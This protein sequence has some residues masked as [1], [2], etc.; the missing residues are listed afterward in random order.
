MHVDSRTAI[1]RDEAN[2]LA[3][4]FDHQAPERLIRWALETFGSPRVLICTSFQVE[5]MVILDL[6]AR[7]EPNIRVATIDTGRLPTATYEMMDRVRDKYDLEVETVW[8]D[9]QDVEPMVRQHGSNLFYHDESLRVMCC[10]MR[11]VRPLR[12][13]LS[14][15]DAW[16]TG[17]RREQSGLR[18]SVRTIEL[19]E[20]HENRIKISPLAYWTEEMVWDY[21][22][23]NDVPIHPLYA[24]GYT[25]IGCEPC[26]R[27]ITPG[28][29]H[30]AGRW[31]WEPNIAKECGLHFTVIPT[32]AEP[33]AVQTAWSGTTH[34]LSAAGTGGR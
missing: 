4:V 15:C 17:L 3:D 19:D 25:S 33:A 31:W 10:E 32:P 12:R 14:T 24:K 16:F 27:A 23:E 2:R 30:R 29:D 7:I 34:D 6:A 8:P 22:R 21:A 5:G 28:E 20:Q 11:K 1:D 9:P 26:T 18:S 13:L